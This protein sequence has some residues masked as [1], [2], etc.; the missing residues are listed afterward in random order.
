MVSLK[1]RL[2]TLFCLV[3][4]CAIVAAAVPVFAASQTAETVAADA[5]TPVSSASVERGRYIAH[6]VAMCVQCHSPRERRG[7]LIGDRLFEGAPLPLKSPYKG[8]PR[9][10]FTAPNLRNA[11][12]YTEAE[13]VDFMMSGIRRNGTEARGPM[14]PFR[15]NR[16]DAKAVYDYLMSY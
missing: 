15:M 2:V 7:E 13:F 16:A 5:V 1:L 8:A 14:P 9:W 11:P 6:D 10:A 4:L 12:G 3:G